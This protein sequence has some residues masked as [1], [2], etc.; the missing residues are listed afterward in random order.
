L[1]HPTTFGVSY[2]SGSAP[3]PWWNRYQENVMDSA[4]VHVFAN[5]LP[6]MHRDGWTGNRVS[7]A[8]AHAW[9]VWDMTRKGPTVV[10]R[11]LWTN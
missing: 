3:A 6:M 2:A 9:F 1:G 11:I 8:V 7:S 10:D 4:R 5:R